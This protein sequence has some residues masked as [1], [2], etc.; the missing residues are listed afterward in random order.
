MCVCV[1]VCVCVNQTVGYS[2]FFLQKTDKV[3]KDGVWWCVLPVG[4]TSRQDLSVCV[5]VYRGVC[6]C[7]LPVGGTSRQELSVCGGV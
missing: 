7:V 5:V 4:G 3:Y 6:V 1:C 2:E